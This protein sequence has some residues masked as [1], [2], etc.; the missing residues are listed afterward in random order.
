MMK[1]K[2][3]MLLPFVAVLGACSAIDNLKEKFTTNN[4]KVVVEDRGT[5]EVDA[6]DMEQANFKWQ[7]GE[8]SINASGM[9]RE[10]VEKALT[11][12]TAN[13]GKLV[14]Y[15]D[16]DA[17]AVSQEVSQEITKHVDFM[18]SNPKIRLRLEG[19]AD[20]RGTREYNLALGEN[21]ALSI[22]EA[23]GVALEDRIEV[24]SYGEEKPQGSDYAKNRRV[25]FI[26]K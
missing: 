3:I 17:A 1:T 2:I 20:E 5:G 10:E 19:H 14:V 12:L 11:T 8:R 23:L 16:Y 4:G 25:E 7:G 9:S 24:V 22:K 6:V 15:F 18:Q 21:R 13:D 26:Y